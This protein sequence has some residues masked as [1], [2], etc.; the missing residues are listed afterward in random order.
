MQRSAEDKQAQVLQACRALFPPGQCIELRILGLGKNGHPAAGWFDDQELLARTAVNFDDRARPEGIYVTLNPVD[1]V[2]LARVHNGVK[3]YQKPNTSDKE[4][5][6]RHWLPIDID[7]VRP[8]GISATGAELQQA[9]DLAREVARWLESDQGWPP[10]IRAGSGNGIHLLYRIDLPNDD[11]ARQLV[12]CCLR[13]LA[14]RFTAQGVKVD[15]GNINA[16]RI[17]K[18]YGTMAR[19]GANTP[20]RPHRRSGL[21]KTAGEFPVFDKLAC[22][23]VAK[24]AGLAELDAQPSTS[25]A[26]PRG[27]QRQD[28][29]ASTP[30]PGDD[31]GRYAVDL[32]AFIAEHNIAVTRTEPFDGTGVRHILDHCLFDSTHTGTS[33]MIGRGSEGGIFYKCQHDSCSGRTWRD[34]CQLFEGQPKARPVAA[35]TKPSK[36]SKPSGG[37]RK[38]DSEPDGDDP[39]GLAGLMLD[40]EFTDADTSQI[41]LRR[42]RQTFY[43]YSFRQRRYVEMSDDTVRVQTTRF[44]GDRVDKCSNRKVSDVINCLGAMVTVPADLE[45]PFMSKIDPETRCSS[46]DPVRRNCITLTNGILNIDSVL[47]GEPINRC[48]GNHTP[49][50]FSTTSLGFPFPVDDEDTACPTWLGFLQEVFAGDEQRIELIQEAFGHCFVPRNVHEVFWIF[51]GAGRNGKSTVLNVLRALLGNENVCSLSMEQLADRYLITQLQGKLANLCGDMNEM[52]RVQ[53]GILKSVVSGESVTADRKYK[54]SIQFKPRARFFFATNPLPRFTDTSIGIWRRMQL[55]PFDFVVDE[56]REDLY[57]F[58]KFKAELPGIFLWALY[59]M[60]RLTEQGR[61]SKSDRCLRAMRE[62]RLNCFPILMFLEECTDLVEGYSVTI[63]ELWNTY[64][65][66]GR[67]CGLSKPKPIHQFA[68]DVLSFLA[69]R[70]TYTREPKGGQARHQQIFGLRLRADAPVMA[71]PE[72][73]TGLYG[74][75]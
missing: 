9:R 45:I 43:R 20:D 34:V 10:G 23:P 58:D 38:Q 66:W 75:G 12:A 18:L 54:D 53:E 56:E 15:A 6:H 37:K 60:L 11:E 29:T 4:I 70:V 42:H 72:P 36:P 63:G 47:A 26:S 33:A 22:V 32:D 2:C 55:V 31:V 39:W 73:A 21:F 71:G 50:W 8:A 13:A 64:R 35:L 67:S 30:S 3:E 40:E 68:K 69:G 25:A 1:P 14:A 27:R 74:E 62:Y 44:L 46:G 16:A 51:H 24:L 7:P 5:L 41:M 48:L 61:F 65:N 59:G 57:L 52:D 19:K 17:W 49:E 28:Q